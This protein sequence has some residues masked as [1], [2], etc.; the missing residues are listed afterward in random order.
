[1]MKAVDNLILELDKEN[2]KRKEDRPKELNEGDRFL[3]GKYKSYL[4][5]TIN[6]LGNRDTAVS[7]FWEDNEFNKKHSKT[8][9]KDVLYMDEASLLKDFLSEVKKDNVGAVD[10]YLFRKAVEEMVNEA[11]YD[12]PYSQFYI[13]K[14]KIKDMVLF[15]I[16]F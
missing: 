3:I 5:D 7:I 15:R 16:M 1:M 9:M 10:P 11:C 6:K 12:Y 14:V 8:L 2:R 13:E 4:K